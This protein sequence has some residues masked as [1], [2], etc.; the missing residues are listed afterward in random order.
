MD[1]FQPLCS[2]GANFLGVNN[3]EMAISRVVGSLALVPM[4]MM[5]ALRTTLHPA[6]LFL[7]GHLSVTGIA[8]S[9]AAMEAAADR[10]VGLL[11][12]VR[13]KTCMLEMGSSR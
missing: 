13:W 9:L 5:W 12:K 6:A 1:I 3:K 8:V 7:L 10:T 11:G 4:A 2:V